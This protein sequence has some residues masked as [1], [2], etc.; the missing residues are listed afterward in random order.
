M[1]LFHCA[2]E[3]VQ[4]EVQ[5]GVGHLRNY[6]LIMSHFSTERKPYITKYTK[7]HKEEQN[8]Q[9]TIIPLCLFVPFVVENTLI[10]EGA[11]KGGMK[12]GQG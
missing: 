1:Q 3:G 2:E 5:D 7:G 8:S 12:G 4:V 10:R 6:S 9:K 11:K